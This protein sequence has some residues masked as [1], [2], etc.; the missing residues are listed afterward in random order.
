MK[1]NIKDTELIQYCIDRGIWS[2]TAISKLLMVDRRVIYSDLKSGK[3][4]SAI[5]GRTNLITTKDIEDYIGTER[6]HFLFDEMN[7]KG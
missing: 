2:V 4:K 6:A 5:V 3:L 7:P 1:R